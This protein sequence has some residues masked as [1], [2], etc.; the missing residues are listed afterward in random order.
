MNNTLL[1]LQHPVGEMLTH[2]GK[3]TY[4]T[5]SIWVN[6]VHIETF[7][8]RDA[9]ADYR[10]GSAFHK[11][12]SDRLNLWAEALRCQYIVGKTSLSL[13]ALLESSEAKRWKPDPQVTATEAAIKFHRRS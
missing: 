8:E 11:L 12:V 2:G 1:L 6:G 5:V 9:S 4:E 3:K 13:S 7:A 10:T